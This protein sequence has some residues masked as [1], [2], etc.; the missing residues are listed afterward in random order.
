[1][2]I[3]LLPWIALAAL[4]TAHPLN[5]NFNATS[6][7]EE[8]HQLQRRASPGD[9]YLRILPLGAS[10]V[11]GLTST[12]Y[13]GYAPLNMAMGIDTANNVEVSQAYPGPAAMGWLGRK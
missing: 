5:P 6:R 12:D 3:F 8:S 4:V 2:K 7:H 9:F 1:M 11:W 13:N 10:I